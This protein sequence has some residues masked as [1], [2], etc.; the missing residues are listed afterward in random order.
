MFFPPLDKIKDHRFDIWLQIA[1]KQ[2]SSNVS[3]GYRNWGFIIYWSSCFQPSPLGFKLQ[4]V[5]YHLCKTFLMAS[6]V[7]VVIYRSYN[8]NILQ[9][10]IIYRI[11]WVCLKSP[12]MFN[13]FLL[14]SY[15][16]KEWL[17]K[18]PQQILI[19]NNTATTTNIPMY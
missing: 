17:I 3:R 9:G 15:R 11:K 14:S 8:K 16:I 1:T 19:S 7:Y 13:K 18:F 12:I 5:F 4:I 6:T 2:Y 10:N